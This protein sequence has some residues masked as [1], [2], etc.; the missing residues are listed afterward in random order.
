MLNQKQKII[1]II[2]A[3]VVFGI[4]AIYYINSTKEI[5]E[6]EPISETIL[7]TKDV[8]EDNIAENII[9]H[10][11]GA[12]KQNGIVE[13]KENSRINDVVEAAGGVTDEADLSQVNLAYVV[14][15]GQKIY[16]PKKNE[17]REETEEVI[18]ENAGNNVALESRTGHNTV[19]INR[20]S[21]QE[22]S[23][24][25]GIGEATATKIIDYRKT[26]GN[27]KSK[28]D[29]K[30]VPGIGDAKFENIKTIVYCK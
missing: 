18:Q 11:A 26:N 17:Y 15:D 2:L 16:I 7:E 29:I 25:P 24:L 3:I 5:Y 10:I 28:E 1:V 22:L 6:Y 8:S 4:V 19:N 27:F 30:N 20:A 21:L 14:E 9:I 23:L 12:V 13:V